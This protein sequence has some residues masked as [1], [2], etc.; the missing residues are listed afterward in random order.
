MNGAGERPK[1][2]ARNW[3]TWSPML[4]L[5]YFRN[6][7]WIGMW[8]YASFMTKE[9]VFCPSWSYPPIDWADTILKWGTD[10]CW[11]SAF[12]SIIGQSPLDFLVTINI[13]EYNPSYMVHFFNIVLPS[14]SNASHFRSFFGSDTGQGVW[15]SGGRDLKFIFIPSLIVSKTQW[16][17]VIFF[18]QQKDLCLVE[19]MGGLWLRDVDFLAGVALV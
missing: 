5:M 10:R 6:C 2:I 18:P 3:Y 11:L 9:I 1:H 19:E 12:K 8:K 7:G 17:E 16:S 13:C 15:G 14:Y 4:N